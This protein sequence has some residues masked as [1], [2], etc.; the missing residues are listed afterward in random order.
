MKPLKQSTENYLK[1]IFKLQQSDPRG[2]K[3]LA[4]AKALD[5]SAPAVTDMLRKL[6]DEKWVEY[7]PYKQ[8]TLTEMGMTYGQNMVRRHR[9]WELYLHQ[10]LG[11]SWDKVH[12]EAEK[13]EHAS[14]DALIDRLEEALGFPHYDPHGD[15]IPSKEGVFPPPI[16]SVPL[17]RCHVGES[18]KVV[19]VSDFD[20]DFLHYIQGLGIQLQTVIRLQEIRSF[21]HSLLIDIK[22]KGESISALTASHIFVIHLEE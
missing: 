14:S 16:M 9:L 12:E 10:V 4:L 15:P 6:A 17:S 2:V 3:P 13:L 7:T 18:V 21:D 5:V 8:I 20:T 11:F 1:F 19:R 22:G